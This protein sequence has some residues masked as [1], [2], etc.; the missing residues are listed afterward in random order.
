MTREYSR[1]PTIAKVVLAEQAVLDVKVGAKD[2][3]T[4]LKDKQRAY[5]SSDCMGKAL[6]EVGEES[7][8]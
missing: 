5:L 3:K 6:W 8:V 2:K 7:Q 1:N 4:G